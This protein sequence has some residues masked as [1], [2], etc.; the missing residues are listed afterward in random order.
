L[1]RKGEKRGVRKER[2]RE[3][4]KKRTLK[5]RIS[6]F[7]LVNKRGTTRKLK[8]KKRRLIT[9]NGGDKENEKDGKGEGGR[10][11]GKAYT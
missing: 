9:Q 4:K 6:T 7:I 11:G 1:Q 5:G 2:K 8:T 3:K 10:G